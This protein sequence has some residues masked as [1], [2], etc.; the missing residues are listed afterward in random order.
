MLSIAESFNQYVRIGPI[1]YAIK[2]P[3]HFKERSDV[4][5]QVDHDQ[6]EI[7]I[8]DTDS[9]GNPVND[10]NLVRDFLHELGHIMDRFINGHR[11]GCEQALFEGS[12][13]KEQRLNQIVDSLL[14]LLYE[15][16][17]LVDLIQRVVE[18][19]PYRTYHEKEKE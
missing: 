8:N 1:K 19:S 4:S 5:A 6:C 14:V 2:H 13:E 12:Y 16:P 10:M 15:N 18:D 11:G 9:V 3:Y 7:R 17:W